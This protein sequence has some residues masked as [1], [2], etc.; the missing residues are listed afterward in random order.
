MSSPPINVEVNQCHKFIARADR[1]VADWDAQRGTE[2]ASLTEAQDRFPETEQ[3]SLPSGAVEFGVR[4][5][6][7]V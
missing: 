4:R 6:R 5:D 2:I 7:C 1:R 3:P